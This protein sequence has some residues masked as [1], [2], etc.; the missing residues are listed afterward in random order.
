MPRASW[1]LF[2]GAF[3]VEPSLDL[4]EQRRW[5]HGGSFHQ[6]GSELSDFSFRKCATICPKH[7]STCGYK[8]PN[9]Q[10]AIS[11]QPGASVSSS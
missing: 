9:G 1:V 4:R 2:S 5:Q 11:K 7:I 8:F 10:G 3:H 6:A